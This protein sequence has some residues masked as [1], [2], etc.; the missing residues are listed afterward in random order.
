L[1]I[2][3]GRFKFRANYYA[4]EYWS[5]E[6]NTPAMESVVINTGEAPFALNVVDANGNGLPNV[7]INVHNE[8]G[9]YAGR[10]GNT[11][12]N[13]NLIL[14]LPF[15][16]YE[17][18]AHYR[19]QQYSSEIIDVPGNGSGRIQIA[20]GQV[21]ITV[22]N[23]AGEGMS[24]IGVTVFNAN[25]SYGGMNG[26]TSGDGT[27]DFILPPGAFKFRVDYM[28]Q[29]YWS[30]V[31]AVP[32]SS[33]VTINTQEQPTTI[34]IIDNRGNPVSNSRVSAFH[35]GGGFSGREGTS[36]ADGEVSILLPAGEYHFRIKPRGAVQW[37]DDFILPQ[38]NITIQLP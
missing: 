28:R 32:G 13:G 11:D 20:T 19:G 18:R 37:S 3:D 23:A 35:T 24:N 1:D 25:G 6:V 33:A 10:G 22:A 29:Q 8:Q 21:T 14:D 30:D 16:R 12:T 31:T 7:F 5:A 38:E 2:P 17:F 26:A 27:I 4:Q 36:N 9:S 15:G 34:R